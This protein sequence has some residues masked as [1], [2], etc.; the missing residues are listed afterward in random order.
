MKAFVAIIKTVALLVV[1]FVAFLFI[2]YYGE[3]H[4]HRYLFSKPWKIERMT[5][6][7]F[8][9]YKVVDYSE[10][11]FCHSLHSY[12]TTLEF[13]EMP[14]EG[15]YSAMESR[16]DYPLDD[17]FR[18]YNFH[19][20]YKYFAPGLYTKFWIY[21]HVYVEVEEG[22]KQFK[23]TLMEWPERNEFFKED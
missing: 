13:D 4:F 1:L 17:T 22:T 21:G 23:V 7:R 18:V 20:K 11:V 9:N 15:F 16:L 8:P 19:D 10:R 3:K 12:V 14:D 2:D 6:L 5:G